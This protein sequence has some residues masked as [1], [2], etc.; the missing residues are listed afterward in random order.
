MS[1]PEDKHA[2]VLGIRIPFN[3]MDSA[4]KT[5][6]DSI[7]SGASGKYVCVTGVH[8]IM[9]SQRS[10][11]IMHAHNRAMMCVPDGM[12]LVWIGRKQIH[13]DM[14][15][16]YGP[17]LT[18]AL[19][20]KAADKGFSS[21]FY[22]GKEGIAE[23]LS[24]CMK[25]KFKGLKVAG[26]FCPPFR[27]LE[28]DEESE[29][30]KR[31]NDASPDILWVGL[32]T[33]KQELL[34]SRW[35]DKVNAKVLIGVGAAFDFHTGHLKQAPS[36]VQHIGMEWFFRLCV[37]PSRLWKRYFYNNP[38]FLFGLFLQKTGLKKYSINA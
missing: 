32:S 12:P 23:E 1:N 34:M 33:P 14:G 13:P 6:I 36:W 3:N 30:L 4:V 11:E 22:G 24:E 21:F 27:P 26:T 10:E 25:E 17:D 35:A 31:I 5:I 9:E 38:A 20:E 8:G 2:N 18:L 37:E 16:V 7:Q 29:I 19:L 15:R 28:A